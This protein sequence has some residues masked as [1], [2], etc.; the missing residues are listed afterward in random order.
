M[1]IKSYFKSLNEELQ[2]LKNRVRNFIEG[3]HWLTDGEWKESVL[4]SFLRRNLPGTVRVGRGFIISHDKTSHQ[5]DI[6]IYDNSKP[7]LFRDGDLV[8]VT[9]DAVKGI[10][11]VKSKLNSTTFKETVKKL[12]H[13]AEIMRLSGPVNKFASIFSFELEG[14]TGQSYLDIIK[15]V[16]TEQRKIIDIAAIGS[17]IFI[18]YWE[19]DPTNPT[20]AHDRWHSYNLPGMAAGYF[21]HNIVDFISPD[22]VFSQNNIWFPPGGKEPLRDGVATACWHEER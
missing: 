1:D 2:S 15:E 4:R 11:E 5:I 8:F 3:S 12:C 20:H 9:P 14:G 22:S 19:L 7:I 21:L 16:T 13:D 10:I 6:L 17:A 18:K